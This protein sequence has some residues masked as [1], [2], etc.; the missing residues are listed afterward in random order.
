MK[1]LDEMAGPRAGYLAHK[2]ALVFAATGS[3]GAAVAKEFAGQGAEVFMSGRTGPSVAALA[4]EIDPSGR[5]AHPAEVEALD[6]DSVRA[7]VDGIVKE[8]GGVDIVY[9]G[10]GPRATEYGGG[11]SALDLSTDE[12]FTPLS[13][14]VRSNYVTAMA[15]ARHMKDQGSGVIL[16]ITGSPSRPHTPGASAIGAAFGALENLTRSLAIELGPL[17]IRPVCLRT[18]AMPDTRTIRDVIRGMAAGMN[19]SEDQARHFLASNTMMQ[20]SPTVA[21]TA[22][23]AAFLA[24][25][26]A[27]TVTGTQ[28]MSEIR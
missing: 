2:R 6:E 3:I 8:S 13:T 7:Y 14:V 19:I 4:K 16:F 9:N 20:A 25:D 28:V 12:F 26:Q 22:R 18:S 1:T 23:M 10:I 17:G 24:S 15:A 11:R 21:D 27:R 5:V